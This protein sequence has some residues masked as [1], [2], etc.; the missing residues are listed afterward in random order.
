MHTLSYASSILSIT[1]QQALLHSFLEQFLFFFVKS[2]SLK[3]MRTHEYGLLYGERSFLPRCFFFSFFFHFSFLFL[4]YIFFLNNAT[5]VFYYHSPTYFIIYA[6]FFF[7]SF[8]HPFVFSFY[9][10]L[11]NAFPLRRGAAHLVFTYLHS[12]TSDFQN[13]GKT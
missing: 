11:R 12:M 10:I 5:N 9:L 3:N 4:L 2:F 8:F 13:G 6:F 7:L 1:H